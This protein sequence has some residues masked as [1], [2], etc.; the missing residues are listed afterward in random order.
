MWIARYRHPLCRTCCHIGYPDTDRRRRLSGGRIFDGHDL[1]VNTVGVVDHVEVP[2]LRSVYLPKGEVAT[3][4]APQDAVAAG[5]LFF[6]GPIERA[7]NVLSRA[8][9]GEPSD[10]VGG[11]IFTEYVKLAHIGDLRMVG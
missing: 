10:L 2:D 1:R 9:G 8:I 11:E 6:V 7:I 5:K 3:V 4:G